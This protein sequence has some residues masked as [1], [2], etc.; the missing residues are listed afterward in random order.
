[1]RVSR[2]R[3][4][5]RR[6]QIVDIASELFRLHGFDGVAIPQIMSAAGATHGGFYGHFESKEHLAAEACARAH[7]RNRWDHWLQG[8]LDCRVDEIVH[9]YLTER[10]RDDPAHGCLLAAVAT[11]V[12]R[13]PAS[14]RTVFTNALR[15]KVDL[16]LGLMTGHSAARRREKA[17]AT[18]AGMVGALVLSRAVN[19]AQ[20][21]REILSAASSVLAKA[22]KA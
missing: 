21:S 6:E 1:M 9:G 22:A 12:A 19:D 13:Q 14:V 5:A 20:L 11:D 8:R 7:H 2:D 10:H 3:A 18:M 4:A 15:S 16:L 17:L